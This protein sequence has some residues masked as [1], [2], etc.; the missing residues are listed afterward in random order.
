[1]AVLKPNSRAGQARQ[2]DIVLRALLRTPKTREG[3]IAA[4]TNT[5][6]SKNYVFGWLAEQRRTGTLIQDERE[7]IRTYKIIGEIVP[8]ANA[9]SP[10][11]TWLDPRTLPTA[12]GRRILLEGKEIQV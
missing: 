5:S 8:S 1:M 2:A 4:V 12:T 6:I 9:Q 11:P 10:Y 7:G 3:L